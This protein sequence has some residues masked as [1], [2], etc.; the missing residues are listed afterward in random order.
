MSESDD[1]ALLP[2]GEDGTNSEGNR[3]IRRQ[4]HDGEWYFSV[5]DVIRV[6]TD[7]PNPG[8]Y[9]R[10]LKKR[11]L[12][13]EG[14]RE[15]VTKCNELKMRA[16]DGKLRETDAANVETM[17]RIV[18]SVP[19]PKAEPVK[20]WLALVGA[21]RLEEVA[22]SLEEAQRRLLMR[23]EVAE[24]NRN[25]ADAAANAGVLT[26]RDFAVFQDHGYR[27]MYNGETSRMIHERKGLAPGEEILDWMGSE[28]LAANWFRITQTEAKLRRDSE[29]GITGKDAANATHHEVGRK[30]RQ[31]I[32]ELGGTMPEDLPT[33]AESIREL[34][35]QERKRIET[36]RQ[37]SLFDEEG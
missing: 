32:A 14:A 34:Q 16:I 7:S 21:E 12:D 27:G 9:W 36:E 3:L 35:R 19:S 5:I 29:S 30:V 13:D 6:L 28:E 15:T 2:F 33:P 37:P 24:K 31:T 22:A 20:Q 17:L 11:M 25:L 8:V 26:S 4:W 10:V 23:G 18:Q 1:R